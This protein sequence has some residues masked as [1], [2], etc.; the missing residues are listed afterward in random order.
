MTD[1]REDL[2]N[3]IEELSEETHGTEVHASDGELPTGEG[4]LHAKQDETEET[5]EG[6][7]AP[8]EGGEQSA[9]DTEPGVDTDDATDDAADDA[10]LNAPMGWSP[11]TREKWAALP[12]DVQAQIAEREQ[13]IVDTLEAASDDR[14]TAHAIG[15]VFQYYAPLMQ[16][17]GVTDPIKA[18]A[19]LFNSA[20]QLR[21]G[22]DAERATA[23]ADL[24]G[25]YKIDIGALDTVLATRETPQAKQNNELEQLVN[26]RMAPVND[27]LSRLNQQQA[28][29]QQQAQQAAGQEIAEFGGEFMEDLRF[30]MADMIDLAASRGRHM[31]LEE[32][33]IA[34]ANA[35]PQIS[36]ILQKRQHDEQLTGQQTSI[37]DKRNAA[38]SLPAQGAPAQGGGDMSLREQLESAWRG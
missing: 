6:E 31:S 33:Y 13:H 14:R 22:T 23:L 1:V 12:K 38:S 24:I 7:E 35:H 37:A 28:Q 34:A 21:N 25:Y 36:K 2:D 5:P 4:D 17:E 32:A 30:D 10:G 3:A 18:V 15:D 29:K 27:L 16:A 11:E 8:E 9:A 19:G 26:Q 20:A